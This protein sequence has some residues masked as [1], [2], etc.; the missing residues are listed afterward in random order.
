MA[1]NRTS[2]LNEIKR[3]WIYFSTLLSCLEKEQAIQDETYEDVTLVTCSFPKQRQNKE[4]SKATCEQLPT[5][6]AFE[7]LPDMCMLQGRK[8]KETKKGLKGARDYET[9]LPFKRPTAGS[10][11][12]ISTPTNLQVKLTAEYEQQLHKQLRHTSCSLCGGPS[13]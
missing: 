1:A 8:G 3:K 12:T 2:G 4:A 13:V 7:L 5:E 10:K 11:K 6:T 9:L